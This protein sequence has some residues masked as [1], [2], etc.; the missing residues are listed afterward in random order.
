MVDFMCD[1]KPN[2]NVG[3]SNKVDLTHD[4][5]EPKGCTQQVVVGLAMANWHIRERG[6]ERERERERERWLK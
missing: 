6:R 3:E 1:N 2:G 4:N 5:D